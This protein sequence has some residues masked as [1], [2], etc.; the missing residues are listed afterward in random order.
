MQATCFVQTTVDD[1]D[2]AKHMSCNETDLVKQITKSFSLL[3]YINIFHHE[4]TVSLNCNEKLEIE[5]ASNQNLIQV[6]FILRCY[7]VSFL[8]SQQR[9]CVM[10]NWAWVSYI[11]HA[12]I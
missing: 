2:C 3:Q 8:C 10:F 11:F 9:N 12:F 5:G 1:A 7:C 4:P 6:W